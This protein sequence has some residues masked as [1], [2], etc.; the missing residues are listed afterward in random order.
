MFRD[1]RTTSIDVLHAATIDDYWNIAG[2]KSLSE[3]WTKIHQK[4]ICGFKA[5][6][7]RNRLLQDLENIWPEDRS[8]MSKRS[9]RKAVNRWAEE[10][11]KLDAA[12]E[13]RGTQ[14]F[15]DDDLVF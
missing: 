6:R 8:I 2:N 7:R 11:P 10:K 14:F 4:D 9:Q 15:P 5:E 12:R 13:Q 3:P 1:K